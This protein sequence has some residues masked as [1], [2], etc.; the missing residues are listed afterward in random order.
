M[1]CS[2]VVTCW[3]RVDFLALMYV[4]LSFVF[5]TFPYGILGQVGYLIVS[6]PYLWLLP[7]FVFCQ[8]SKA[9]DRVWH[10]GLKR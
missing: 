2:L 7:Y 3:E 1:S 5:V 4:M 9:F 10:V 8:I 6:I